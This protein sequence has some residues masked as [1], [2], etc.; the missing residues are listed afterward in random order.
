MWRAVLQ[1]YCD[2]ACRNGFYFKIELFLLPALS[3][4]LNTRVRFL[5]I[6]LRNVFYFY[7]RTYHCEQIGL[8][9]P[10]LN[11]QRLWNVLSDKG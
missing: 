2:K 9:T 7:K 1:L 4:D 5:R 10:L 6:L 8:F 3:Y 11:E